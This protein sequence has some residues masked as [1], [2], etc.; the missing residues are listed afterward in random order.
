MWATFRW[1]NTLSMWVT[2]RWTNTLSMW[3]TFRWTNKEWI[4]SQYAPRYTYET[5]KDQKTFVLCLPVVPVLSRRELLL[6]L[7]LLWLFAWARGRGRRKF[8]PSEEKGSFV[9]EFWRK[10]EFW[11]Q[12][13]EREYWPRRGIFN[14]G[15]TRR[16]KAG[17]DRHDRQD[18]HG[19]QDRLDET[20]EA[21]K[22]RQTG[23]TGQAS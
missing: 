5:E 19:R 8:Y 9:F 4:Q 7:F 3:V 15:K 21:A 13:L 17:Q 10:M 11:P 18:K 1:T 20:D 12:R 16:D 6:F 23:W 22:T 14:K 2:F